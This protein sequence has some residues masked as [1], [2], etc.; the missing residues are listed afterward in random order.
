MR[1]KVYRVQDKHGR[2]PWKPG[3]SAQWVEVR[4][5]H[6]NLPPWFQEF[7]RVDLRTIRGMTIGSACMTIEQ[8]RRWFTPSEYRKLCDFGYRAV[9]MEAF[10]VAKSSVQCFV[11]RPEPFNEGCKLI[12]LY[13]DE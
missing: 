13:G 5:D 7:G 1:E 10:V 3:F 12:E 9:T 8:L 4:E 6:D 11:Q 2:G